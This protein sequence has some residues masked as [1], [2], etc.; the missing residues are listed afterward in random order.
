MKVFRKFFGVLVMLAG[1]LGLLLSL[2]GLAG[3]W[4]GKP[5]VASYAATT[6][7][8]LNKT[9]V[10]S[11]SVMD[12]TGQ[13]LGATVDS[14]DALSAML[15]TTAATVEDTKPVLD[16]FSKLMSTTLPATFKSATDSLMTAQDAAQ[17]L[18][19]TMQ[20]L[21]TFQVLLSATPFMGDLMPQSTA[22]YSPEVPLA[23]SLGELA[24]SLKSL[25][26]T[27]AGI[28]ASLGATGDKL[29]SVQENLV[30]MSDSVKLV[31]SSLSEYETMVGQS[32][33]SM[34]SLTSMLS[35]LQKNL[36]AILN[37]AAL[38]LTL[39]FV[40]LLAAQVVILSQGWEIYH[41]TADRMK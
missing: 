39:F 28:S 6:I 21:Q 10:T 29:A 33:A 2:A 5:T 14:V 23:D 25:P 36:G 27:F 16:G 9:V 34:G 22:S 4:V 8:T 15:S 41:G 13:A 31:S 1:V 11:Q 19:G 40:W 17:V 38:G 37:W 30:A 35:G 32:K 26:D 7:D 12:T 24:T 18:E 3:V 20:S